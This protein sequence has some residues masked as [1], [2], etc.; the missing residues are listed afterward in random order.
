MVETFRNG[1]T[2]DL[3]ALNSAACRKYRISRAPQLVE[4]IRA[5]PEADR[6]VLLPKLRA[7]SVRTAS[8]IVQ[9]AWLVL[10]ILRE[11]IVA[12]FLPNLIC[13]SVLLLIPRFFGFDSSFSSLMN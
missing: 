2:V 9:N 3:N 11:I 6:H 12:R 1:E 5:V 10:L 4:M 7:K 13:N 8:G